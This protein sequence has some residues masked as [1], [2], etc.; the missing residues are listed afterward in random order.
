MSENYM[1]LSVYEVYGDN[2]VCLVFA[3]KKIASKQRQIKDV[4]HQCEAVVNLTSDEV[5]TL[6]M[7]KHVL[8]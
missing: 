4:D 7:G 1:R 2:G 6:L 3:N 8:V 5:Q